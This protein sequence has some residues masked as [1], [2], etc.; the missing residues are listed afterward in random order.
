MIMV[1]RELKV[2]YNDIKIETFPILFID[3][4]ILSV[5]TLV[6][7]VKQTYDRKIKYLLLFTIQDFEERSAKISGIYL[8]GHIWSPVYY[9]CLQNIIW[10]L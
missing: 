4:S 6:T 1:K 5:T 10:I 8:K 3:D 9:M 2:S 7:V